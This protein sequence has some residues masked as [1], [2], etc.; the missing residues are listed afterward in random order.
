MSM[1]DLLLIVFPYV[2]IDE[3]SLGGIT[4]KFIKISLD[5][6][7]EWS[8]GIYHNSRYAIF[9]IRDEKIELTSKHF[10]MPKFRKCKVKS[11]AD[12]IRK[13]IKYNSLCNS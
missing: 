2:Y 5:S 1:S 9:Y 7:E 13:L 4:S 3:S 11:D 10:N 6:R 8:N 12:I